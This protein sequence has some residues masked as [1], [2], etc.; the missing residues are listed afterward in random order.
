MENQDATENIEMSDEYVRNSADVLIDSSTDECVMVKVP[1]KYMNKSKSIAIK[2][3][4]V[5]NVVKYY[6]NIYGPEELIP[7][8]FEVD[9]AD[10][11]VSYRYSLGD[12]LLPEGAQV[13]QSDL[14]LCDFRTKHGKRFDKNNESYGAPHI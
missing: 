1:I 2:K 7:K 10:T 14:L 3:G 4:A 9:L 11:D 13:L 6:I 8:R 5:F 12:L